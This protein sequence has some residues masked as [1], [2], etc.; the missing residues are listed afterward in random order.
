MLPQ[1][2]GF[3]WAEAAGLLLTELCE[4][5]CC[6]Q[7]LVSSSPRLQ[8]RRSAHHCFRLGSR[9]ASYGDH[10]SYAA[11]L[12]CR[13]YCI[14]N[15]RSIFPKGIWALEV[16]FWNFSRCNDSIN[17]LLVIQLSRSDV[18]QGQRLPTP[19]SLFN[20]NICQHPDIDGRLRMCI[21]RDP[22]FVWG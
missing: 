13:Q 8:R 2:G 7:L 17:W 10:S 9:G 16:C 11:K 5:F 1:E 19:V 12:N 4:A 15:S 14:R 22:S 21:V 6:P 20:F 3:D 18:A